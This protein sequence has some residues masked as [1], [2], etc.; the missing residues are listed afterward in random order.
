M[1]MNAA[2]EEE[3]LEAASTDDLKS[4]TDAQEGPSLCRESPQSELI[5]AEAESL[6]FSAFP[7]EVECTEEVWKYLT[8]R[9]DAALRKKIVQRVQRIASGEWHLFVARRITAKNR[10]KFPSVHFEFA[11]LHIIHLL[12]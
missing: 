6:N 5:R 10:K 8:G 3:L 12:F 7:W 2:N 11:F 1:N 4:C 9:T